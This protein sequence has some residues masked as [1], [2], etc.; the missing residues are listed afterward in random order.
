MRAARLGL[1]G[2]AAVRGKVMF[3][4]KLHGYGLAIGKAAIGVGHAA[5]PLT[6]LHLHRRTGSGDKVL[7]PD[8]QRD[9]GAD[10]GQMIHGHVAD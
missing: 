8:A 9:L 4:I 3:A 10:G 2:Q 1:H 5:Q 6:G 7:G